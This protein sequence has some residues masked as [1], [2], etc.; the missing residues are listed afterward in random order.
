MMIMS[1][2]PVTALSWWPFPCEF[3][4]CLFACC[5]PAAP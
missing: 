3:L 1:I 4:A 5:K 2:A